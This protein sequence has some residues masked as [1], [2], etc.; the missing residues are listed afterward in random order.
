[1]LVRYVNPKNSPKTCPLCSSHMAAYEDRLMMCKKCH[2]ILDRDV[3]AILN[4]QMQGSGV[5][6]KALLGA[7][8][9]MMEKQLVDKNSLISMKVYQL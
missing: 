7:P 2:L 8:V 1:M 9:S 4:L 3:A 5:V 6:P